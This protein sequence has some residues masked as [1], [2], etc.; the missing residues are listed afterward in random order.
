MALF[1]PLCGAILGYF[2]SFLQQRYSLRHAD[3]TRFHKLRVEVYSNFLET[4]NSIYLDLHTG[5][6][7]QSNMDTLIHLGS[8]IPLIASND[9]RTHVVHVNK[10]IKDISNNLPNITQYRDKF[11]NHTN[12]LITAARKELG[13]ED[14]DQGRV[15]RIKEWIKKEAMTHELIGGIFGWAWLIGIPIWIYF[16]VQWIRGV[17]PWWYFA[18]AIAASFFCKAVA[19]EYNKV[20]TQAL[21]GSTGIDY[22]Q[23]WF[24]LPEEDKRATVMGAIVQFHKKYHP[25][26][27]L[28]A[29]E[30]KWSGSE[31]FDNLVNEITK[32]YRETDTNKPYKAICYT[33]I[34]N[35]FMAAVRA[36]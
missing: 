6:R 19:R 13:A 1:G 33:F 31:Q 12:N 4:A 32:G 9:V 15:K 20:K 26:I 29:L 21:Y 2:G 30:T 34:E 24:D 14:R 23:E 36:K 11:L 8:Q 16:L 5:I 27:D 28:D 17:H 25:E 35:Y 3:K 7:N 10:T 18:I 22:P